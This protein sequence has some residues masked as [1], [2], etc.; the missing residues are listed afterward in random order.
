MTFEE[1]LGYRKKAVE[2][3]IRENL[4][5]GEGLQKTVIEA[6]EYSIEAGGKRLRPMM[7]L[8]CFLLFSDKEYKK[9]YSD[10]PGYV[11][12]YAAALECIHTYSL[13]HDDLPEMD[14]DLLRRGKPTTH[15]KYGQAM[16]VLCGEGLLNYAFEL[17]TNAL[18]DGILDTPEFATKKEIKGVVDVNTM[19]LLFGLN[20]LINKAK[21]GEKE[22]DVSKRMF[23]MIAAAKLIAECSGYKGMLGGQVVDVEKSGQA[24]DLETLCYMYHGKTSALIRAAILGGAVLAGISREDAVKLKQVSDDI[25][26]AFQIRDDILD[27]T[28]TEEELG[29]PINSDEKNGKITYVTFTSL[30]EAQKKVEELSKSSREVFES[31]G[32]KAGFMLDLID[33]LAGRR[34]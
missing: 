28:S 29:K 20:S 2:S 15:A 26:M 17:I 1:E 24:E 11:K 30:E 23:R 13:V 4:P 25:G 32:E 14:N 3:I 19:S 8:E 22:E 33:Y 18:Y 16:G 12:K 34:F 31:Y 21:S 10:V 7:L 9:D 6:M 27:V 5:K